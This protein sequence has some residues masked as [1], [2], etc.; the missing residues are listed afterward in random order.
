M[1]PTKGKQDKQYDV[2]FIDF[3]NRSVVN[4][5]TDTRKLPAHLLA[6]EPQAMIA[7]FAY[8]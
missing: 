1:G 7:Y 6:F 3:G 2:E 8:I 5:D 4:I